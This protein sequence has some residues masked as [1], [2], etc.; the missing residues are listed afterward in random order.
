MENKHNNGKSPFFMGKST[1]SMATF[2]SY[3]K[4]PEVGAGDSTT[5]LGIIIIK[6]SYLIVDA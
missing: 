2:N 4:L 1:I 6:L 3:L 5:W